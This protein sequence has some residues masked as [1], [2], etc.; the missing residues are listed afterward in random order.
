MANVVH[1]LP[2]TTA[3]MPPAPLGYPPPHFHPGLLPPPHLGS[4]F[5]PVAP[6]PFWPAPVGPLP[7]ASPS[8]VPAPFPPG[9]GCLPTTTAPKQP[10]KKAPALPLGRPLCPPRGP[11]V[12]DQPNCSKTYTGPNAVSNIKRHKANVHHIP[13]SQQPRLTRWD[14][15]PNRPKTEQD[16]RE[17]MLEAKRKYARKARARQKAAE[18]AQQQVQ[19][20]V[21][22][23][24]APVVPLNPKQE[25]GQEQVQG[26]ILLPNSS[27]PLQGQVPLP[28][29]PGAA[30]AQPR[31]RFLGPAAHNNN[32]AAPPMLFCTPPPDTSP[33][34]F[35]PPPRSLSVPNQTVPLPPVSTLV[36]SWFNDRSPGSRSVPQA[37]DVPQGVQATNPLGLQ[38]GLNPYNLTP[39]AHHWSLPPN[40]THLVPPPPPTTG[41]T[42]D[43]TS[44][45]VH[46][47]PFSSASSI[48]PGLNENER[49]FSP[50]S[51]LPSESPTMFTTP[52]STSTIHS[53]P[54]PPS[55][56]PLSSTPQV[57]PSGPSGPPSGPPSAQGH[58]NQELEQAVAYASLAPTGLDSGEGKLEVWGF[59]P[60]MGDTS[61]NWDQSTSL[62]SADD[63]HTTSTQ[64]ITPARPDA[65]Q[66]VSDLLAKVK[67]EPFPDMW[68]TPL[69]ESKSWGLEADEQARWPSVAVPLM[70]GI[71][72]L[73]L[74]LG[75]GGRWCL[76]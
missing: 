13:L 58:S 50:I 74:D 41:L 61:P 4:A 19:H 48:P 6:P 1:G 54:D 75:G 5:G 49:W 18:L 53:Y 38:M 20:Q 2:A 70:S 32:P 11:V 25:A 44:S 35:A 71:H 21:Q 72:G 39:N 55:L 16:R 24:G 68:Y 69:T 31:P 43:W 30:P 8:S 42:P 46:S 67:Q 23:Q 28:L 26:G 7:G 62:T 65:P 17:R 60:E 40:S 64:I 45:S 36:A 47:S 57:G 15:Y 14:R 37:Q 22:Q 56:L 33:M 66:G 76:G 63:S 59:L 34:M 3:A 9:S 12:C 52:A 73:K 27:T 29:V 10:T 51:P